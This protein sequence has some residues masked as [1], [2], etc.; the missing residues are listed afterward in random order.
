MPKL[1]ILI[2]IKKLWQHLTKRRRRQFVLLLFLMIL[3]SIAEVIS[4]GAVVPFLGAL[5]SPEQI[6]NHHLAQPLIQILDIGDSSQILLPFT[7][8]FVLAILIAATIRLLLLHTSIRYSYATGADI[9]IEIYRRTLYQDYSIHTSRNSSEI[10]NS[11][12]VKTNTV[13]GGILVPLLTFLSSSIIML[14]IVGIVFTI[15]TKVALIAF[16]VFALLY[17]VITFFTKNLEDREKTLL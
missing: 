2:M 6:Y 15:N 17:L 4:I 10:I 16:S 13:I 9:S 1:E 14:G 12:I 7:I 5:T 11:I 8:I 3:S